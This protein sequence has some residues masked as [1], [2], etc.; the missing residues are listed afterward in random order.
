MQLVHADKLNGKYVLPTLGLSLASSLHQS[1]TSFRTYSTLFP[2]S[3]EDISDSELALASNLKN[4]YS[5][6]SKISRRQAFAVWRT[7]VRRAV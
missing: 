4:L 5:N 1:A 3:R 6:L 2:I 7:S